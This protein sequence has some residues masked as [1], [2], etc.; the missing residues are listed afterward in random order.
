MRS[1]AGVTADPASLQVREGHG[2][3]QALGDDD[4][5]NIAKTIDDEVLPGARPIAF[6]STCVELH[7]DHG[8]R[9]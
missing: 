1:S 3:M 4:K 2:G 6:R 7:G 8:L 5:A 9:L